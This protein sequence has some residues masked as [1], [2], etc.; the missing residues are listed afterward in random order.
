MA[1][2]G[3]RSVGMRSLLALALLLSA[4]AALAQPAD[5]VVVAGCP[6]PGAEAGCLVLRAADGKLYDLAGARQRPPVN[7][8]GIRITGTRA[9]R[10]SYCQ[11]GEALAEVTWEAT[12]TL[13]PGR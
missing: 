1:R 2:R 8:R 7:G 13:C 5:R 11:Q 6:V 4:P 10:F 3:V 12:G 9:E